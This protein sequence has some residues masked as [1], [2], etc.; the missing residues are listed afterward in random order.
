MQSTYL[1]AWNPRLWDWPSLHGD[2]AKLRRRGH[3]D[4]QWSSGR[5][6]NVEPGSRAFLVKLGVAPKGIYGAGTVMTAPVERLHWREDKAA[7]GAV[8]GYVMLRLD[9]LLE[10]PLVTFDDLA[11]PP[12][13]RY[14]WAVRQSGTRVPA[15]LADAL[16]ALWDERLRQ[17]ARATSRKKK[18]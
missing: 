2:I 17:D 13:T 11:K 12:F 7:Q 1:F 10:A 8:T 5:A 16:E 3:F 15:S 18:R 4:T 9:T 6:R 14:R